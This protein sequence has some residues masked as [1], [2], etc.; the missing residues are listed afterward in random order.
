MLFG[1]DGRQ[2]EEGTRVTT[3]VEV[4]LGPEFVNGSNDL[5]HFVK[6]SR[7]KHWVMLSTSRGVALKIYKN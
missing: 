5:L 7:I 4:L 6:Y 2:I 1:E 3:I